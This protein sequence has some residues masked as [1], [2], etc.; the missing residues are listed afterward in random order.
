MRKIIAILL[1]LMMC[2]G[3][4]V[5]CSDDDKNGNKEE[6]VNAVKISQDEVKKLKDTAAEYLL[7]NPYKV[8]TTEV[9]DCES[10][11]VLKKIM[12]F[13]STE[14]YITDGENIFYSLVGDYASEYT[15]IDGMLYQYV[16]KDLE[17]N[18]I[19]IKEP[20]SADELEFTIGMTHYINIYTEYFTSFE[21]V[22]NS[23]GTKTIIIS[24][25]SEESIREMNES[26]DRIGS[27][28]GYTMHITDSGIEFVVGSKGELLS[29]N[30]YSKY[31]VSGKEFGEN[32]PLTYTSKA[33]YEYGNFSITAPEDA[34]EYETLD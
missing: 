1:V 18:T 24:R 12:D 25:L 10:E 15:Y 4:L 11:A 9:T 22:E 29:I 8:T 14:V 3:V 34:D 30:N 23:D 17:G 6:E 26:Y 2:T 5:A 33:I 21:C 16:E 7:D 19:K 27:Y 32:V 13:N 20:L 28:Q 31:V